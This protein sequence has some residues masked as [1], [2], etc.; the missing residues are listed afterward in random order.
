VVDARWVE[1]SV[2]EVD[3]VRFRGWPW[4]ALGSTVDEFVIGKTA[5]ATNA[6][7]D[8]INSLKPQRIVE[9]GTHEGGSAALLALLA[10]PQRL[11]TF[12]IN[13]VPPQALV[14]LAETRGLTDVIR[15][16]GDVSQDDISRVLEVVGSEIDGPLDL[17]IDDASHAYGK[18]WLTFQTLFP[19]VRPGGLYVIEDWC[20]EHRMVTDVSE[21]LAGELG[22]GTAE[23]GPWVT[24]VLTHHVEGN[25]E[26]DSSE[27]RP[28]ESVVHD[29]SA[30]DQFTPAMA[31]ILLYRYSADPVQFVARMEE[32]V[33]ALDEQFGAVDRLVR[34]AGDLLELKANGDEVCEWLGFDGEMILVR[35]GPADLAAGEL[36]LGA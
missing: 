19:L 17:V 35:R 16:Y 15:V 26:L 11:V 20:S 18:T 33:S 10:R 23:L 3:G 12:D 28:L 25:L 4:V 22:T 9:V 14:E 36:R 8:L 6:I 30:V 1:E 2:L 5:E 21:L 13:P 27:R 31:E 24:R 34:L 29:G 32:E 7:I